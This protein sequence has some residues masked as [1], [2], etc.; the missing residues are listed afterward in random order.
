MGNNRGNTYSRRTVKGLYPYQAEFWYFSLD[1]LALVDVPAM[2]DY[3]L[4][5]TGASKLAFVGHSQVGRLPSVCGT[6]PASCM[7]VGH[8]LQVACLWDTACQPFVGHSQVGRLY[9]CTQQAVSA[10]MRP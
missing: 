2:I 6:Q 4:D 8:S 9:V 3:V 7:L 10:A 1:E 5:K